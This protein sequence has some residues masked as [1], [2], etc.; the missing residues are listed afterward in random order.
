MV[1]EGI[2]GIGRDF[3]ICALLRAHRRMALLIEI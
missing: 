1:R 2:V 3:I